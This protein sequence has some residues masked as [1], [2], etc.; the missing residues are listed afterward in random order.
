MY[1]GLIE[2]ISMF[3]KGELSPSIDAT[4]AEVEQALN[5]NMDLILKRIE[6]DILAERRNALDGILQT[7]ETENK[8]S[9]Y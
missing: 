9:P 7:H 6:K 1:P 3:L 2:K 4:K 8:N 5:K